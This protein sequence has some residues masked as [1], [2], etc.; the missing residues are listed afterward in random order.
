MCLMRWSQFTTAFA[1]WIKTA[2]E[3]AWLSID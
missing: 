1:A 2:T 3:R